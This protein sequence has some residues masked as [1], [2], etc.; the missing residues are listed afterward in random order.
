MKLV[1]FRNDLRVRDNPALFNAAQ[2]QQ[3]VTAVVTLTPDQWRQHDDAPA[4]LAFWWDNLKL[5]ADELAD[6]HIP[7]Q[8]LSLTDYASCG[9]A[10]LTLAQS[11]NVD[12]LHF[13]REWP[14]H[15]LQ[16]DETVISLFQSQGIDC[17]A[18]ACGDLIIAPQQL[19]TGQGQ[20]FKVF[21]PFARRWRTFLLQHYPSLIPRPAVQPAVGVVLQPLPPCPF[22]ADYRRDLWPAGEEAAAQRLQH[23]LQQRE[24]RY[25]ERR[26]FPAQ[27]AT[28]TLSPWLTCGVLSPR[29]CLL[30]LQQGYQDDSWLMGSWLNELIWRE[31]YRH[32][33]VDYPLISR[34]EPFR[35]EVERRIQ[36][37]NDPRLFE[38][39]CQGETGFDLVD[40]AMKQLLRTGW[41]HNRLRMLSAA[42][43]T[44][45]LQVDWRLGEQFFMRHL[46]DGDF[47]S[48]RGGWQW[49]ASVGADAAPYFRI[50]NPHLQQQKFDAERLF[51]QRWLPQGRLRPEPVID[52][53]ATRKIVLERYK[54]AS[55]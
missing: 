18:Q 46:I 44:K 48:N 8:V 42:F 41:M 51:I 15:E 4:R 2:P 49:S 11:L 13:N 36:W 3:G 28:S 6:Y 12:S 25:A 50:F 54:N 16:R 9:P 26:D 43:L 38:A 31:F 34:G 30:A 17:D 21:T 1:W 53:S 37:Q 40:A 24:A 10:L 27:P 52:Y 23:F 33:I 45:L 5:L 20:P 39:W 22:D 35:P 29:Q 19:R 55:S 47:A 32:L 7:L 14:L